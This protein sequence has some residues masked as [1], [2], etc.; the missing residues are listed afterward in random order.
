M[1]DVRHTAGQQGEEHAAA[2]FE[3]LG[4]EVLARNHRTRFGELDLVA[5]DGCTLVFAEVKTRRSDDR[6]PWENLHFVKQSKV[7][8]MAIAWLTEAAGRPFGAALRFDGV[9]VLVDTR[10]GL[11]RLDHLEAAF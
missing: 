3:R 6:E 11:I 10:G 1:T 9:A 7:R 5:Y 4:F 8:R 2:H